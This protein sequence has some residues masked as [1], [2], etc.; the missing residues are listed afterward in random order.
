WDGPWKFV[1]N[2]FDFDE[3]YHLDEDPYELD[4]RVDDPACRERLKAMTRRMWATAEAT[5]DHSLR[6]SNYPILRVA[7]CGWE[8]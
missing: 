2:G 4:N 6:N 5:G 1:F 7:A 3:L 8:A